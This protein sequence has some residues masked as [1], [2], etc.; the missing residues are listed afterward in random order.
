MKRMEKGEEMAKNMQNNNLQQQQQMLESMGISKEQI[1]HLKRNPNECSRIINETQ[2][3]IHRNQILFNFISESQKG[4]QVV[5][6]VNGKQQPL[7]N[8]Q[9]VNILQQQDKKINSMQEELTN[10]DMIIKMLEEK[11]KD[12]D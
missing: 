10:K 1:E 11:L 2:K 7:N 4:K 5:T 8:D 12:S 9:I 3:M 6:E